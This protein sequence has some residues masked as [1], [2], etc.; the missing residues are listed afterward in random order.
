MNLP[1]IFRCRGHD[2]CGELCNEMNEGNF[3]CTGHQ[4]QVQPIECPICFEPVKSQDDAHVTNCDHIFHY[5]CI[6]Q[7]RD[8]EN[9]GTCPLCRGVIDRM[10]DIEYERIRA[11]LLKQM[12][13]CVR[14]QEA[15]SK[16]KDQTF[17]LILSTMNNLLEMK[18]S[19]SQEQ[20][21]R[22][23]VSCLDSYM[24]M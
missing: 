8:T 2:N 11:N 1:L 23:I 9:G 5:K 20:S 17:K 21:L 4:S 14:Y 13:R 10:S 15:R 24:Y 19:Q 22:E 12:D 16:L 3:Y 6:E 18:P 7:W